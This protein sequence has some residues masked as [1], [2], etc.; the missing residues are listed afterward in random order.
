MSP[1]K[2]L[3]SSAAVLEPFGEGCESNKARVSKGE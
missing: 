1:E 3:F 2:E